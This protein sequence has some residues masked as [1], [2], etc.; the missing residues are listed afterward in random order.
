[1]IPPTYN[2]KLS[3]LIFKE[4]KERAQ[5]HSLKSAVWTKKKY[6]ADA[7]AA[8]LELKHIKGDVVD[9]RRIASP[10]GKRRNS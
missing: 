6:Q 10:S 1:M 5:D 4:P 2:I 9:N 8:K 7:L 3:W